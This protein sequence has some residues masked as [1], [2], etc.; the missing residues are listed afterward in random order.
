MEYGYDPDN[1]YT[2][3]SGGKMQEY[4]AEDDEYTV[5]FTSFSEEAAHSEFVEA[6]GRSPLRILNVTEANFR[7]HSDGTVSYDEAIIVWE[8]DE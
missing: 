3:R 8:S 5:G 1:P 4:V 6:F 2:Y 7:S